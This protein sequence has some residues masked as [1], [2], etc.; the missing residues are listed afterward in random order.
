MKIICIVALLCLIGMGLTFKNK[1]YSPMILMPLTFAILFIANTLR[2]YG[3]FE[4]ENDSFIVCSIGVAFFVLGCLIEK[5]FHSNS[6]KLKINGTISDEVDTKKTFLVVIL[7][8]ALFFIIMYSWGSIGYIRSGGTLYDMRYGQQDALHSSGLISFLYTYIGVPIIYFSL[9][10]AAYDYFILGK[11]VYF[12]LTLVTVFFWFAGNGA[13]LPLIYLILSIVCVCLLFFTRIKAQGKLKK[14]LLGL[15]LLV[16]VI[17]VLSIARRSGKNIASDSTTFFQGLYYYLG[18]SMI[19]MGVKLPFVAVQPSLLGVST[20]YGFFLP[21]SNVWE[22][23]LLDRASYIPDIV[24]NSII[25]ISTQSAQPYN[26]GTTGFFY[27]FADGKIWG[28][29]LISLILGILANFVYEK[30][31]ALKNLK[32]FVMYSL[33]METVFMFALTD[34]LA[35]ISFALSIIYVLILFR[36]RKSR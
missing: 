26:F 3:L 36:T 20:F 32:Y 5:L 12:M 11:K 22:T 17:D 14:I 33:V 29:V 16:I 30:F 23:K 35:T 1:V 31:I 24:Q 28:V 13:R 8:I 2:L 15:L 10:I 4:A 9:P 25:Q 19:N 27:L 7:I 21:I 18:G 6:I 34:L